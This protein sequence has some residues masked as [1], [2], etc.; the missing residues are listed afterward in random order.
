MRDGPPNRA[1]FRRTVALAL[2]R[3]VPRRP[4]R[5]RRR[6]LPR[7]QHLLLRGACAGGVWKTTDAGDLLA[8][9]LRRLL[10]HR[11][12]RR[13]GR[14]PVRLQRDLRRHR[15]DDD[16]HRRL[17][18][19]RRLQEHRR[20]PHLDAT[21]AC[22]TP[23][24]S[25]RSA[26]TR[27][28]PDIVWVAALGH[29]FGPNE[30]RG[31]FK[32]VDGGKTWQHVLFVSE[33]A[34]AVDL[35]VDET[36]P[37]I[38]Y[39]TIWEAYRSLLDDLLRRPGQRPLAQSTDGGDTWEN[40]TR[41]PGLPDGT[42]GK[43]G[44]AASPAKSGRVWA[45]IEHR[46]RGRPLPLRR[47]RR[48][49]GEG[50]R[51]PEPRLPRLVLRPPHRRPPGRRHGLRQQ[52]RLLEEH[53]RRQDLRRDRHAPRRQPRPLDRPDRQPA[54]DPGQRRRRQRLPQRR[55]HLQHDLQPAD[56]PVLPPRHR[57][58]RSLHRLRH[59]AGQHQHRRPRAG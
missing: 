31:V 33:K 30:E 32:S 54:D 47:L 52:P 57:H 10:H 26:S 15:R 50:L 45:L 21:S 7:P 28:N 43:I 8:A 18:R 56:R 6:Q 23:A 1:G 39:A 34:G 36:N 25:A 35:S 29:A 4:R 49:L 11:L 59:P 42:L 44:V 20:R 16:P 55:R 48:Q 9:R 24:T 14:R 46:D 37:R 38:L 41:N 40:I 3:A 19:R 17:P 2:H 58:Q 5:R 13:A 22:A 12:G 51:Q 53:R 27:S